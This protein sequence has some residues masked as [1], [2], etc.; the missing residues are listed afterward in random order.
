MAKAQSFIF[1]DFPIGIRADGREVESSGG[2]A[3][4]RSLIGLAI[5]LCSTCGA[6]VVPG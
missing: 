6:V 1:S 5:P 3:G 2:I 4:G